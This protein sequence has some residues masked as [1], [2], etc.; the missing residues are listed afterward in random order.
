M[1]TVRINVGGEIFETFKST[2]DRVP[3]FNTLFNS[4]FYEPGKE[5]FVDRDP[6]IFRA[7]LN[8]LRDR[9]NVFPKKYWQDL[10]YYGLDVA[11]D[12]HYENDGNEEKEIPIEKKGKNLFENS[13]R[14]VHHGLIE[15]VAINTQTLICQKRLKP[16]QFFNRNYKIRHVM[17]EPLEIFWKDELNLYVRA[18]I[19]EI[20]HNLV[21][22]FD[23]N[24]VVSGR[25]KL[26][27][28]YFDLIDRVNI[29]MVPGSEER[30]ENLFL[31]NIIPES[32]ENGKLKLY[33]ECEGEELYVRFLHSQKLKKNEKFDSVCIV[34]ILVADEKISKKFSDHHPAVLSDQEFIVNIVFNKNYL[35]IVEDVKIRSYGYI[36]DRQELFFTDFFTYL[37]WIKYAEF[38]CEISGDDIR[39]VSFGPTFEVGVGC[40]PLKSLFLRLKFD[41]SKNVTKM[42][43]YVELKMNGYT[44]RT[45][46][47]DSFF[48]C[49]KEKDGGTVLWYKFEF[50]FYLYPSRI[51][52]SNVNLILSEDHGLHNI[53]ITSYYYEVVNHCFGIEYIYNRY[54]PDFDN[55][56]FANP[57]P[58]KYNNPTFNSFVKERLKNYISRMKADNKNS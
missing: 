46:H 43:K 4:Q 50:E 14:G 33:E 30:D 12:T 10:E 20:G 49:T 24:E 27:K 3:Y 37:R 9:N 44:N 42:V 18:S 29:Y 25:M 38:N 15:F 53:H 13:D 55:I 54:G 52:T 17:L 22:F 2:I 19:Q 23:T 6:K 5:I 51:D 21:L 8:H 35:S 39:P 56:E 34:P 28:D 47:G 1:S 45:L 41:R 26:H 57:Y 58:T 16:N 36:A 31:K 11:D 7:L 48:Y 32:I 40:N